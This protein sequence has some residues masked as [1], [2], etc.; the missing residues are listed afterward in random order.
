MDIIFKT[1]EKNG[2]YYF[3]YGLKKIETLELIDEKLVVYD[4]D[5]GYIYKSKTICEYEK[6]E[7]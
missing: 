1:Y 5:F 7:E 6:R 4:S 3:E 2:K